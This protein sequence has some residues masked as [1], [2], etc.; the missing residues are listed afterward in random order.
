MS[1][2][3]RTRP[4]YVERSYFEAGRS[5]L[6]G[7]DEVMVVVKALSLLL[8][9]LPAQ[10]HKTQSLAR[11]VSRKRPEW[12]DNKA[13]RSTQVMTCDVSGRQWLGAL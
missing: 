13:T 4:Q 2:D 6:P 3:C 11:D 1:I 12:M 10:S 8:R 7:I 5:R 9:T